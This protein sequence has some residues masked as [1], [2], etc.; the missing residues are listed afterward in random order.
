MWGE[1]GQVSMVFYLYYISP[2]YRAHN[3]CAF[4]PEA[5]ALNFGEPA[6]E[7]TVIK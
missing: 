1:I 2:I 5:L 6:A 4:E 7:T 3:V